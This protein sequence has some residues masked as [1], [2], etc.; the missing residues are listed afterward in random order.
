I[1]AG[2]WP[3]VSQLNSRSLAS[4]LKKGAW[5]K[6]LAEKVKRLGQLEKT[7]FLYLSKLEREE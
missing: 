6:Q 2:K 3:E 4:I 5:D 1:E 7:R